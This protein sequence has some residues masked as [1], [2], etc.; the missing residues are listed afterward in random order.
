MAR[1]CLNMIVKNESARIERA[2]ATA[3]PYI[4][5]YV[6]TD[7]GSTDDTVAVIKAFFAK[8]GIPGIVTHTT[9][10][11]WSQA[12]NAALSAGRTN[13]PSWDC[14]YLLLMD[15]DMELVVKDPAVFDSLNGPSY[16]M[17]QIVGSLEYLNRRL[18]NVNTTGMYV[19]VTHEYLNVDAVGN[20]NQDVAYFNDRADGANRPNKSKRDIRLLRQGIKDEPA[21]SRYFFYL[22]QSYKD[23]GNLHR[24]IQWYQRRVEA[25]GWPEE[26]WYAQFC[27]ALCKLEQHKDS[28]FV[29]EMLKAYNMRPSRSES[30][31]RLAH[32]YRN[33]GEN[34][35]ATMYAETAMNTPT[36]T[37]ALFVDK[38]QTVTGPQEEFAISG[39]YIDWKRK[40]A[41][42]VNDQLT[43]TAGPYELT[44]HTARANQYFYLRPLS[45]YCPSFVS[46]PL[47]DV[48]P[49]PDYTPMN[50]SITRDG[51]YMAAIIRHVNYRM[52]DEGR[53]II[54]ATDGTANDKNPIDTRNVLVHLDNDF[55]MRAKFE[56]LPPIDMPC[57]WPLVTGFEDMRLFRWMGMLWTSSTVRQL[58]EDGNCEQV[59]ARI[60]KDTGLTV[61]LCDMRRMLREPRQTEK[62]WMPFVDRK[63]T[64]RFMWRVNE[65]VDVTGRTIRKFDTALSTDRLSGSSQVIPF[66]SGYL[67]VVH[68]AQTLPGSHK[69]YYY[70]RF[71]SYPKD[72]K[73]AYVSE[74]FYFNDKLIEFCAGLCYH[75]DGHRLV[76]SYGSQDKEAR[77]CTVLASEV[78]N[79][80]WQLIK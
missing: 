44:R 27:L 62:N 34:G 9:F 33:K 19:G 66:G 6:I 26:Q 76:L 51:P 39:F 48:S 31:Y 29:I 2:L 47:P 3:L 78:E 73:S 67:A 8:A 49:H 70:H 54:K 63:D 41:A 30:L 18:V 56:V 14:D 16:D 50:P 55:A 20:I 57:K 61:Q 60:E 28:E 69:R 45:D 25:G 71:V 65:Q 52:D 53:Y 4:K 5:A 58:H 22:A 79:L 80:E 37:D 32:Y 43:I 35:L 46:I 36:P 10:T 68:E 11:D 38:F 77:V 59:L 64:L 24:A 7:T 74:P 40:A 17:F 12:R 42:A 21:N 75:P 1:L 72:M 15:A 23:D 13:A